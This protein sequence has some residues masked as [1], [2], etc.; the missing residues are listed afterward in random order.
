MGKLKYKLKEAPQ[1]PAIKGA[2]VGDV[3]VSGGIK[4]TITN[5]NPETGQISWDVDYIPDVGE[6]VK[7]VNE[8]TK[9]AKKV[10]VRAKNDS[11]FRDIY[12][13]AKL[14]RNK[15]RTHI[16]NNYPEEYRKAVGFN[17]EIVDEISTSAAG[18][19]YLTPYAFR[20]KGSKP[21]DEAYKELGY[22][23]VKEGIGATLGPG[24]KASEDG[25]KD[26][27]YVKAFKYKLVPKD[28]Q[29]NYVQKGSGLEVKN[30][31][32]EEEGQSP[33]EFHQERMSGFDR[34]GDLLGQ[35]QPLLKDAKKETEDYY[36]KDS[37]SYAVVYG[38]DLVVDYLNDI[39]SILKEKE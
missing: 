18:G 13:D 34:I 25:V 7:D 20:L 33:K 30:L 6:L 14:L 5:I 26:N 4:S 8:L 28:K 21:N 19:S 17:E 35:I 9:T 15:I 36:K 38:T 22:K 29:G 27:Y 31:F 1:P 2:K 12:D 37:K 24:P 39:I 10:A 3:K 16:R 32:K 11:K 23:E